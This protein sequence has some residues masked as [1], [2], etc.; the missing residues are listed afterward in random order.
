MS[1]LVVLNHSPSGSGPFTDTAG[2]S[3]PV[4]K[5]C[6]N[7][8]SI[9]PQSLHHYHYWHN[10]GPGVS[11]WPSRGVEGGGCSLLRSQG[12]QGSLA[13]GVGA[14]PAPGTGPMVVALGLLLCGGWD[15]PR[16]GLEPCLPASA[17]EFL[18]PSHPRCP[19]VDSLIEYSLTLP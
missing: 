18:A 12:P 9:K 6:L 2:S 11:A 19:I 16:S 13:S 17:G 4:I 1:V 14:P 3:F 7:V 5:P 8:N 15:L 10:A